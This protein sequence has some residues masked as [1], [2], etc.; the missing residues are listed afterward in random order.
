MATYTGALVAD[1]VVP[2]W[3]EARHELPLLFAG[4]SAAAAGGIAAALAPV[5]A[6]RPARRLGLFGAITELVTQKVMEKRWASSSPSPTGREREAAM[7][8][9]PR[10]R[11]SQAAP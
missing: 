6:A 11:P 1:S 2:A 10:P 3:H 8:R 7:R 5:A 4:S 9:R